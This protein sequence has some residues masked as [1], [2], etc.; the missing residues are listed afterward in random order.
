MTLND[1]IVLIGATHQLTSSLESLGIEVLRVGRKERL[2]IDFLNCFDPDFLK[3]LPVDE[4]LYCVNVGLLVGKQINDASE[5]EIMNSIKVNLI[6][7][8]KLVEHLLKINSDARIVVMGS[9]S[10]RKG[11]FDTTYFLSKAALRQ[12]VRQ[13]KVGENQQLVMISPSTIYD[14]NMTASRADKERLE[15]YIQQHPKKRFLRMHEIATTLR[16]VLSA[17]AAYL[18]NTE[19]EINGGKFSRLSY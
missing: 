13:R 12:F 14:S 1:K 8:T 17:D 3:N 2:Q 7:V 11:S 16:F 5:A 9:E 19:I 4:R 10:G 18:T 15:G 6:G